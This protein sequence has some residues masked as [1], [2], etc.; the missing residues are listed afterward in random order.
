MRP[1]CRQ[2]DNLFDLDDNDARP[3]INNRKAIRIV[4]KQIRPPSRHKTPPKALGLDIPINDISIDKGKYQN[5]LS[6]T[7]PIN[8]SQRNDKFSNN[9]VSNRVSSS[10]YKSQRQ[11]R[12]APR[13]SSAVSKFTDSIPN[14]AANHT[15]RFTRKEVISSAKN[16]R[17]A[18]RA[19]P[20]SMQLFNSL[21]G[22]LII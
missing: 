1:P 9:K 14:I 22:I 8:L 5:G 3:R 6:N 4:R 12:E 18:S 11:N 13:G 7:M 15:G 10:I 19:K 17:S 20:N 21:E 2:S 16:P